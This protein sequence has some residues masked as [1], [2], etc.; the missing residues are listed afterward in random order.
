[1]SGE[2]TASNWATVAKMH[3][4]TSRAGKKASRWMSSPHRGDQNNVVRIGKRGT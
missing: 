4:G 2:E 1:M 3:G